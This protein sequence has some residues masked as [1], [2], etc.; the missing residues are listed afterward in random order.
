MIPLHL[1]E[2][3]NPNVKEPSAALLQSLQL[4]FDEITIAEYN[5]S[6]CLNFVKMWNTEQIL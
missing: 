3:E 6:N 5:H 2:N 4:Q 1:K